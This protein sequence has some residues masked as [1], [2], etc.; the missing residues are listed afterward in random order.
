MPGLSSID[1]LIRRL[2]GAMPSQGRVA[3][4]VDPEVMRYLDSLG[5]DGRAF[6]TRFGFDPASVNPP[7]TGALG[8][9]ARSMD[10]GAP[11]DPDMSLESP[12][13][14]PLYRSSQAFDNLR[15][16]RTPNLR[17]S[18]GDL[19]RIAGDNIRR[20]D[21]AAR[22]ARMTDK[23]GDDLQKGAVGAGVIGGAGA[24][25]YMAMPGTAPGGRPSLPS[26]PAAQAD[27][28]ITEPGDNAALA[29]E[30]KPVPEV[31]ATPDPAPA[32]PDYSYQARQLIDQLNAMRRQA[33]GEVPQAKQMMAEIDRL[34]AM[35]NEQK[36]APDYEE[37]LPP[38]YHA[39][40]RML[41]DKLNAMRM[42]AGGEVPES[43]E[44]MAEVRRLQ[45]LGD[46]QRNATRS[47]G[48]PSQA[49]ASPARRGGM[50]RAKLPTAQGTTRTLGRPN[51]TL[52]KRSSPSDT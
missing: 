29:N 15:K 7:D 33:G 6:Y 32:K 34:L 14:E 44:I 48:P 5:A 21:D 38:D 45:A 24:L 39:Q 3:A 13:F 52:P 2:G 43:M 8:R 37:T 41:L 18:G 51:Y 19:A 17:N 23:L 9:A 49:P 16:G 20:A 25:G 26:P 40:A 50:G 47:Y 12:A 42:E 31:P 4:E 27:D 35:S 22:Q 28:A 1:D 11:V 46:E 30:S 10:Q 36:N